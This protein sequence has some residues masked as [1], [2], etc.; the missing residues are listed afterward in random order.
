MRAQLIL[1]LNDEYFYLPFI[2]T[3]SKATIVSHQV[4]PQ[5]SLNYMADKRAT[6]PYG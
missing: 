5:T 2:R 6:W 3:A 4:T 1:N